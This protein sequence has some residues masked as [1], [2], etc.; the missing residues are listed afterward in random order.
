[1]VPDLVRVSRNDPEGVIQGKNPNQSQQMVQVIYR[2]DS[3]YLNSIFC[4]IYKVV[5][6]QEV[7][8]AWKN[9]NDNLKPSSSE[10]GLFMLECA[11][12]CNSNDA[13]HPHS[14][15]HANVGTEVQTVK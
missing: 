9:M 8:T 5:I 12:H 1:M 11:T 14:N 2:V 4:C 7:R 10:Q 6:Y 15:P 3:I 13:F